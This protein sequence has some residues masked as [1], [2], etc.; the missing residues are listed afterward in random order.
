MRVQKFY[1][2]CIISS[3][4]FY[5]FLTL[6]VKENLKLLITT[7]L[8][9]ENE[10]IAGRKL[11]D[12][13]LNKIKKQITRKFLNLRTTYKKIKQRIPLG[14]RFF[15]LS[16]FFFFPKYLLLCEFNNSISFALSSS[17]KIKFINNFFNSAVFVRS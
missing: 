16:L 8:E 9:M 12:Q 7:R 13:L 11:W 15:F 17:S 5:C 4:L 2:F 6:K 10:F 1:I 3:Y 14:N